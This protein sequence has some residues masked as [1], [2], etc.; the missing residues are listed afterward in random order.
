MDHGSF[1]KKV[2]VGHNRTTT[3][4][5]PFKLEKELGCTDGRFYYLYYRDKKAMNEKYKIQNTA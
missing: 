3:F 4:S 1:V 2:C 5:R